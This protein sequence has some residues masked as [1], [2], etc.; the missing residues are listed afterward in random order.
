MGRW[1]PTQ[2][3]GSLIHSHTGAIQMS[4]D[5]FQPERPLTNGQGVIR[6]RGEVDIANASVMKHHIDSFADEFDGELVVDCTDLSFIDSS[7]L[8]ALC[9]VRGALVSSGRTFRLRNYAPHIERVLE[10]TGLL[11]ILVPPEQSSAG[12]V[13]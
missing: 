7:G 6:I 13:A 11:Q 4:T 10:L 5:Q 1:I 3:R 2:K 12:D 8:S 9:D